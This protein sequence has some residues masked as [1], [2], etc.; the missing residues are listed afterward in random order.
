MND[1]PQLDPKT[2]APALI[3]LEH[4]IVSRPL[5]PLSGTE[6]AARAAEAAEALR[7]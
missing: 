4:G 2:T 1:S 7:S 5:A 3:D 6:V